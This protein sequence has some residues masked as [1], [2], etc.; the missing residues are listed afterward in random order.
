MRVRIGR[1]WE[2]APLLKWCQNCRDREDRR[3]GRSVNFMLSHGDMWIG[4]TS[5]AENGVKW[6]S[7]C[8]LFD[9]N[10]F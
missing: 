8:M 9:S 7:N 5:V 2:V 6:E 4:S 1:I 10:A 3:N